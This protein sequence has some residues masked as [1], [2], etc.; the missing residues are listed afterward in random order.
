M[1]RKLWMR[2]I[3]LFLVSIPSKKIWWVFLQYHI[4]RIAPSIPISRAFDIYL[5][6]WSIFGSLHSRCL[7]PIDEEALR[8]RWTKKAFGGP[9]W[10]KT[11]IQHGCHF[12]PKGA[13]YYF[14]SHT[15]PP[16][17]LPFASSLLVALIGTFIVG[18]VC[19]KFLISLVLIFF[20][21][22]KIPQVQQKNFLE[23]N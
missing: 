8:T 10:M 15:P 1:D 2:L 18:L 14:P 12:I 9:D 16:N 5:F 4:G 17:L 19:K 21:C 11:F 7:F 23:N 22:F 20:K 6:I 3:I 13:I